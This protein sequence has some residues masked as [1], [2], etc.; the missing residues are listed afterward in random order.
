M[1]I[2]V[3]VRG[4]LFDRSGVKRTVQAEFAAANR[5]ARKT[6]VSAASGYVHRAFGTY[7]RGWRDRP[8]RFGV[9]SIV[10]DVAENPMVHAS[11]HETGRRREKGGPGGRDAIKQWII[12][13]GLVP[14]SGTRDK[15]YDRFAA[16]IA[17]R[18][19]KEGWPN[20]GSFKGGYYPGQ[21]PTPMDRAMDTQAVPVRY[22]YEHAAARIARRLG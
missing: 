21:P 7:E 12:L 13:R 2:R 1:A 3:K 8:T 5:T 18:H 10:H 6:I 11:V 19:Y 15:D 17:W 22:A 4:P 14:K 16:G 9:L 20:R